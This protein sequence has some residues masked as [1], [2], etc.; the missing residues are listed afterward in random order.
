MI[1]L[2]T[3]VISALML[4]EPDRAVVAWLDTQP[5]ESVWTTS[6]TLFEVFFGL[7]ILPKGKRR[8]RL[9]EAFAASLA[10]DWGSRVLAFDE[11]AARHASTLAARSRQDGRPVEIRDVQ[12]AGIVVARR[13]QL[14]TRNTK[15]FEGFGVKL[16]DPW[17][18]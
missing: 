3:N 18:N 12:I 8:T 13:G 14:A 7:A 10:E 15:H 4:R 11:D 6:V 16:V 5:P 17:K 1:V 2:D 9:E